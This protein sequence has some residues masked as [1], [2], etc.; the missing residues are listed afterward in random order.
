MIHLLDSSVSL[1][2]AV[3][4]LDA[5]YV[6][7]MQRHSDDRDDSDDPA[8]AVVVVY[9]GSRADFFARADIR[10]AWLPPKSAVSTR[11]RVTA[12]A[13]GPS[14]FRRGRRRQQLLLQKHQ[15]EALDGG[16]LNGDFTDRVRLEF[17]AA[18]DGTLSRLMRILY[19]TTRPPP[20]AILLWNLVQ[21]LHD[22]GTAEAAD[23]TAT[24]ALDALAHRELWAAQTLETTLALVA[25]SPAAATSITVLAGDRAVRA[26]D[27]VLP[28]PVTTNS[29]IQLSRI[30]NTWAARAPAVP[31]VFT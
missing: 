27:P 18:G 15:H 8:A 22:K 21:W 7:S 28:A 25:A 6:Q 4:A 17:V 11:T 24:T 3:A 16:M 13:F 26:A 1:P 12:Q 31:P 19:T 30:L 2:A 23:T 29:G 5:Q 9:F 20:R 10:A 14:R